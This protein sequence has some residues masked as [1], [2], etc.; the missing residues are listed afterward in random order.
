MPADTAVLSLN[1]V[2][3]GPQQIEALQQGKVIDHAT[4]FAEFDVVR[5]YSSHAFE[6]NAFIGLAE[7]QQEGCLKAKRLMST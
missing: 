5:V 6:A 4:D 7:V 1:A 2:Q 3:L